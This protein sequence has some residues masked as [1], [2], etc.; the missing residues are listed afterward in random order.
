MSY[1]YVINVY[2]CISESNLLLRE[3]YVN[4]VLHM[5]VLFFFSLLSGFLIFAI[6]ACYLVHMQIE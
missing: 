1:A 5:A 4:M 2:I 3:V 6:I